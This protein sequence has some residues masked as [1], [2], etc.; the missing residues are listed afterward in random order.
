M[1]LAVKGHLEAL[2]CAHLHHAR[3]IVLVEV[4]GH[5]PLG[6]P[7]PAAQTPR[8]P[9]ERRLMMCGSWDSPPELRVVKPI[10]GRGPLGR[11]PSTTDGEGGRGD[12]R[13]GLGGFDRL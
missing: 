6:V 11:P 4:P 7:R 12:V 13:G 5:R 9:E 8:P 10:E 1:Q 3:S 2:F